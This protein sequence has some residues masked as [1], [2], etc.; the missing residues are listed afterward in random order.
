ME[1]RKIGMAQEAEILEMENAAFAVAPWNEAWTD[2]GIFHRYLLDLIGMENALSF[3][4]YDG[5]QL[6]G[7]ALGRLKHWFDGIEYCIDDLCVT[8]ARQGSGVGSRMIQMI[9]AY[10]IKQG[11]KAVSLRTSRSA[12][13][14]S[15][16]KKN[17]FQELTDK[18]FLTLPCK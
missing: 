10:S 4:L 1:L 8:P 2:A 16:Y 11:Y 18:V 13:A 12:A 7:I 5:E 6:V 3:G 15:F 17:G 14:Y 9:Q